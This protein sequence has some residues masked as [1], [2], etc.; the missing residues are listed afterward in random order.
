M[1]V[2]KTGMRTETMTPRPIT[3]AQDMGKDPE[4][5]AHSNLPSQSIA[6]KKMINDM[7]RRYAGST[8]RCEPL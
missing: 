1:E 3:I 5:R 7:W 8:S 2:V 4:P 6:F